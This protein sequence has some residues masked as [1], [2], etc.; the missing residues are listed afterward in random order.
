VGVW[1]EAAAANK[2]GVSGD[3]LARTIGELEQV[4][5]QLW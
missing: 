1:S 4:L 2:L 5:G 3:A